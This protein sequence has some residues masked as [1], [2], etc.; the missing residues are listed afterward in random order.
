MSLNLVRTSE[1][2]SARSAEAFWRPDVVT[3]TVEG[4]RAIDA[5][6]LQFGWKELAII[7]SAVATILAAVWSVRA[8][9]SVIS[10][11]FDA[12]QVRQDD[13]MIELRRE[14]EDMRRDLALQKVRIDENRNMTA[15][16]KG[17]LTGAGIKGIQK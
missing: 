14:F 9:L 16:M 13:R 12:A 1:T 2:E 8:E 6:R 15:E 4:R 7:A 17:I 10:A 11:K 5:S 3:P